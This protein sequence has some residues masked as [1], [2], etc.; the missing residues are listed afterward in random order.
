M[1]FLGVR[2]NPQKHKLII[3]WLEQ[4]KDKSE[5]VRRLL[6]L[7]I[8][9]SK[10]EYIPNIQPRVIT[11]KEFPKDKPKMSG[12]AQQPQKEPDVIMNILSSF[13]KP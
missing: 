12:S 13:D 3:E 11:W 9:V 10:G 8:R 4:F 7:G 5:E 1:P 6:E 2:L